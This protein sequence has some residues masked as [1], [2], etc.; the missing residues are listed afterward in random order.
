M[1][2]VARDGET[3]V[4]VEVK[5]RRSERFGSGAESVTWRKRH[6]LRQMA[7][8]FLLRANLSSVPCRFDVVSVAFT[9]G[10]LPA[11]IDLFSSAFRADG[12]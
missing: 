3:V 9:E 12:P 7:E 10:G 6:K 5:A 8:D 11:R 2:I 1:D 4:F